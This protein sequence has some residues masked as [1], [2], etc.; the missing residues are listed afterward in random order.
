MLCIV[1]YFNPIISIRLLSVDD[2]STALFF[3][4]IKKYKNGLHNSKRH[5]LARFCAAAHLSHPL[6][7]E[8]SGESP[9]YFIM[10][11]VHQLA[12]RTV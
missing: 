12:V 11:T 9:C 8:F 5:K 3:A 6:R 7:D 2:P 10:I 4:G 1:L